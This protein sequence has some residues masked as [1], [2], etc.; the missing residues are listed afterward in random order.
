MSDHRFSD[1]LS[2]RFR[3]KQ[4]LPFCFV[5]ALQA[6]SMTYLDRLKLPVPWMLSTQLLAY[7]WL[8][9]NHP[10]EQ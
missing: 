1:V 6:G 4:T 2:G 5:A 8:E 3:E 9:V 7:L 10:C